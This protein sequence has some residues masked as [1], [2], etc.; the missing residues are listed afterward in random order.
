MDALAPSLKWNAK[1]YSTFSPAL[2]SVL[3][4]AFINAI[5]S[6]VPAL[7]AG[8]VKLK[9]TVSLLTAAGS[10]RCGRN[11]PGLVIRHASH[12]NV[13]DVLTTGKAI[14]IS[15]AIPVLEARLS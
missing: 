11:I 10:W 9:G 8:R 12:L 5:L 15:D 1:R 13:L 4:A 14:I 7:L 6:R 3:P 2:K